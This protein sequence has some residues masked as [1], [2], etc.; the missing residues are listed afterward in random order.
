MRAI[1]KFRVHATV[2]TVLMVAGLG[3]AAEA[4]LVPRD[5]GYVDIKVG[6]SKSDA[7][8]V[9]ILSDLATY[10]I[11]NSR[12]LASL[13]REN[14]LQRQRLL[15]L[16]SAVIQLQQTV[17][18]LSSQG[19]AVPANGHMVNCLL[20]TGFHGGFHGRSD[21]KIGAIANAIERC[22]AAGTD[23]FYCTESNV[24]CDESK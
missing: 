22:E 5:Y 16:E 12:D 9:R 4:D 20:A 13:A 10:G 18:R 21:T 23:K 8:D 14:L 7:D 11:A 2:L 1:F 17:L 6:G 24:K 3:Q 15:Q 19:G